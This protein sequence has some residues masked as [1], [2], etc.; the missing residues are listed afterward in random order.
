MQPLK[1]QTGKESDGDK[2]H[3][4]MFSD[5]SPAINPYNALENRMVSVD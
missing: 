1:L 2:W 4:F 3:I 5:I